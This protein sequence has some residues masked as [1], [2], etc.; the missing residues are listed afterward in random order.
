MLKQTK[1]GFTITELVIVIVVIAILAAVLI[2]TF[3]SLIKKANQSADIQAARQMDTVLQAE[4][5]VEKPA[6]LKDVMVILSDA[7]YNVDA[8]TPITKGHTFYWCS[9]HN[10]ILLAD[11]KDEVLYPK[12]A[13]N[14]ADDKAADKVKNLMDGKSYLVV[15]A[16]TKE[17]AQA[18]LKNGQSVTLSADATFNQEIYIPAGADVT[19]DLGGKAYTAEKMPD[20]KS[21]G[22]KV[23]AGATLTVTNGTYTGRSLQNNGGTVVIKADAV[24]N[25]V[26]ATGGGCIRNKTGG[27]VIIEGG[28]F[29]APTYSGYNDVVNGIN[30]W[31]GAACVHNAGGEVTI[32]GGTFNSSTAAY[33]IQNVSGTM[34]IEDA[35]VTAFR[36]AIACNNGEVT[37]NGGTYKVT[38]GED[39]GHTVYQGDGTGKVTLNAGTF[40]MVD[41]G[42]DMFCGN[43]DVKGTITQK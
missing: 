2:P 28:T 18:G 34:T 22:I 7:G 12:K 38:N 3:A 42:V 4:S 15:K 30:T 23:E 16:A 24:I 39:S 40:E 26:D 21:Y 9:E 41:N 27:K 35:N 10:I 6:E 17:E 29:N 13:E 11:D 5:A 8:L 19:L 32:K 37:V 31:G 1:R 14:F 43:V 36:G 20:G 33:A 25:A